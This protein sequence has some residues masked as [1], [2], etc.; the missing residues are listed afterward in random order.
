MRE[1]LVGK[2]PDA[3]VGLALTVAGSSFDRIVRLA[4][5]LTDMADLGAFR[6]VPD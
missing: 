6:T 2:E 1:S 3:D 5:F 4:V